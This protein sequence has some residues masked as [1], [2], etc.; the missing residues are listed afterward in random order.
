MKI[1]AGLLYFPVALLLFL[2]RGAVAYNGVLALYVPLV[3]FLLW[4][5]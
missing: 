4:R 1:R 3:T 2:K 5:S